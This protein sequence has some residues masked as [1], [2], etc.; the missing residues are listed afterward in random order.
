[1]DY[2]ASNGY[3]DGALSITSGSNAASGSVTTSCRSLT[4]AGV[5]GFFASRTSQSSA[6]N[7][8]AVMIGS[9][10][11]PTWL[12]LGSDD[13]VSWSYSFRCLSRAS[14]LSG[15]LR[16]RFRPALILSAKPRATT[17]PSFWKNRRSNVEEE[18]R[19]E[20]LYICERL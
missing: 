2:A 17:N 18:S 8:G 15:F 20:R 4:I 13:I 5:S 14:S 11:A 3:A 9:G 12:R 19:G 6:D 1:M 7:S 10:L 16:T